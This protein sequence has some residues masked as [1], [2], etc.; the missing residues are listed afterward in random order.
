M[1]KKV[2]LLLASL[3]ISNPVILFMLSDSLLVACAISL[4]TTIAV[5]ISFHYVGTRLVT[6]YLI[7]FL[8]IVS[9]FLHAEIVFR[10]NF[11]EYIIEDLYTLEDGFYFNKPYLRKRFF[12]KEFAVDYITNSQ[13][14]RIGYGQNP[15]DRLETADWLFI[16][17][18]FTQGAQVNFEELYTTRLYE[19]FPDK[20]VANAGIS[21]L[22]IVE[23]YNYYRKQGYRLGADIVFLQI[24]SFNDFMK[25]QPRQL[26]VT[27]YL[28]HHSDFLRF[29]LQDLKYENPAEL[30]LGRWTEPFYPDPENNENYNIF[31]KGTT[32]SKQEDLELFAKYLRLFK[33][34]T[35]KHNAKLVVVLLPTK[36]QISLK[37]FNEVLTSFE[38]DPL[39]LDMHRPNAFMK[40]LSQTMNIELI[41]LLVPLREAS[42]DVFF[43]YD[44]HLSPFGH[45]LMAEQI[46]QHVSGNS[47]TSPTLMS[48]EL[49]GDRY[50]ML[51]QDGRYIMYQSLRDGNMEL[52]IA[53]RGFRNETRLTFNDVDESHPMLSQDNTTIVFTQGD[54][55]SVSD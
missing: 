38:I 23:E 42:D 47:K 34:E 50:P 48:N 26:A 51:S 17:D 4:A 12:D 41:D 54:Q 9:V 18:S 10:T 14:F 7:N 28:M 52:F 6:V 55:E 49:V 15:G 46:A 37:Y 31:Y 3:L 30:P 53:D 1:H 27:D 2:I 24:C 19:L 29:L 43:S 21:G 39:D 11:S 5:Q 32:P 44:E 33:E 25:V 35:E 16:G 22:G 36:E 13:G 8:T 20:I 45:R 40:E